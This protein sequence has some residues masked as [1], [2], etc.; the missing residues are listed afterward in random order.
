MPTRRNPVWAELL[1]L[2]PII[3]LALPFIIE[4]KAD[5]GRAGVGFLIGALLTIPISAAVVMRKHLLNPI[6]VGTGLWLWLG[7]IAF[8]FHVAPLAEWLT[9]TQAFGL[10]VAALGVGIAAT[11]LSRWGYV[12]CRSSDPRWNRNVSLGLLGF[13]LA[14]V[15]WAWLLRH[16]IRL[17][18]GL[19]FIVLNVARRILTMRAPVD[20]ARTS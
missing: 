9:R 2:L 11:V 1:Q 16:D 15:V 8:Q 5:V 10:F 19:P 13:T 12:A 7:A 18:G 20:S 14:I 3:S 6:L 4:G 17:G